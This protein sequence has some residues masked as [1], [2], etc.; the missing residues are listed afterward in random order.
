M[1]L[2]SMDD[3]RVSLQTLWWQYI[4]LAWI[5]ARYLC[6][7]Y[8]GNIAP[9]WIIAEYH[10]RLWWQCVC[11][12]WL[13]TWYLCRHYDVNVSVQHEWL[14][15]ISVDT[16]MVMC[17]SS[18]D[19]C[20]VSLQTVWWQYICPAWMTAGYLCRHYDGN[21]IVQHGWLQDISADTMMVI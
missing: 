19:N 16:V 14:Q 12:A 5:I 18:K 10:C 2:S 8:D 13:T 21:V 11:P 4:S 6:R 15:A 3:C 1:W 9:A 20:R 17:L 7:H